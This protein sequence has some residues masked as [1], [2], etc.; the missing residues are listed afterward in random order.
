[1]M[2]D[3]T[4]KG[5]GRELDSSEERPL[6]RTKVDDK[7]ATNGTNSVPADE[8]NFDDLDEVEHDTANAASGTDLY[9]DTVG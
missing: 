9:L 2:A 4:K 3:Q 5:L 8:D 6:K 1:M 7:D